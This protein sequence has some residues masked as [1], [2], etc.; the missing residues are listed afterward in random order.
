MI[1]LEELKRQSKE[2]RLEYYFNI[3]AY[4]HRPNSQQLLQELNLVEADYLE[5]Q[6]QK[7]KEVSMKP[8]QKRDKVV[9]EVIKPLLKKA[10]FKTARYDWW[11]ELDDSYLLIHMDNSRWNSYSTGAS[12]GFQFSTSVRDDSAQKIAD[13]WRYKQLSTL[14]Q[15]DFL[16]YRG[17]FSPYV[18]FNTYQIDGFSN[19]LPINHPVEAILRQIKSDF[20]DYILPTLAE[21][22]TLEQWECL[23]KEKIA[24]YETVENRLLRYYYLVTLTQ[25]A[26]ELTKLKERFKLTNSDIRSHLDWLET[27]QKNSAFPNFDMKSLV[28][29]FLNN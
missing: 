13:L 15:S 1:N 19:Y 27:L 25:S 16:P 24:G 26:S 12:F 9:K 20:E 18:K 23:Y 3:M 22:H 29:S 14:N 28:L 6:W 7:S 2:K 17:A 5:Y 4:P 10:G 11:K 21:I 8:V